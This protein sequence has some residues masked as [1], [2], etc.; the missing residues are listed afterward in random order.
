MQSP[1]Q[2]PCATDGPE[3]TR[4]LKAVLDRRW[5]SALTIRRRRHPLTFGASTAGAGLVLIAMLA[6]GSDTLAQSGSLSPQTLAALDLGLQ[7][8]YRLEAIYQGA[9]NDFGSLAPFKEVL[10]AEKRHSAAIA[11]LFKT[12]GINVPARRWRVTNVPHF[13]S[14]QEACVE[15]AKAERGNTALYDRLLSADLPDDVRRVFAANRRASGGNHTLAFDS[16][17]W[18]LAHGLLGFGPIATSTTP[19][20]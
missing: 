17:S 12:R 19:E 13:H 18:G 5:L 2:I 6:W 1:G 7:D 20:R 3:R 8:E 16:C 11:R 4:R 14:L 15:G 10:Q 9:V